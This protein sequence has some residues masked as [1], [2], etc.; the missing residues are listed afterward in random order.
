MQLYDLDNNENFTNA[1][2]DIESVL[3][4]GQRF[5]AKPLISI[6]IPTFNRLELL[7]RAI[8]SALD[9]VNFND[10]QVI[11]GDNSGVFEYETE[12]EKMIKC[13]NDPKLLYYKHKENLGAFGNWNR[14]ILL[15]QGTYILMLHDDDYLDLGFLKKAY[16]RLNGDKLVSYRLRVVDEREGDKKQNQGFIKRIVK[17]FFE[18]FKPFRKKITV[19]NSLLKMQTSN[20]STFYKRDKLIELGGYNPNHKLN[21]DNMMILRYVNSV[22]GTLYK[23]QF[24]NYCLLEN[25]T[26]VVAGQ[27]PQAEFIRRTALIEQISKDAKDKE[28]L[29]LRAKLVYDLALEYTIKNYSIDDIL[30]DSKHRNIKHYK[31]KLACERL[32]GR[33]K[34]IIDL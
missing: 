2:L 26:L 21:A 6:I 23:K 1:N 33:V 20:L 14:L 28:K 9:Q 8:D 17:G 34:P 4:H 12:V 22:G 3:V 25:D 32:R 10:Y 5:N 19:V 18:L 16:K 29:L 24:Y 13:Y 7:K 30:K 15:A 27:F 31:L 11:V